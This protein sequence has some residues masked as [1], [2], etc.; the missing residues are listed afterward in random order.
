MD[1]FECQIPRLFRVNQGVTKRCRLSWLTSSALYGV[2]DSQP[3]STVQLCTW[4]PNIFWRSNSVFNLWG[5]PSKGERNENMMSEVLL[6]LLGTQSWARICKPFKLP[7]ID[8][9][10]GGPVL[11]PHLTHSTSPPGYMGWR[12]QF[13]GSINVYK[14]GL[15]YFENCIC[16]KAL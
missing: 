9:Q 5:Y 12:N 4:S 16:L 14:V 10:P 2:S 13:P 8:S 3:V 15:L 6:T 7:R 11:Q 1:R